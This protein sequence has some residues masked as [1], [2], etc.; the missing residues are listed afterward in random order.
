MPSDKDTSIIEN[1]TRIPEG[2]IPNDADGEEAPDSCAVAKPGDASSKETMTG[3]S[4][5]NET[6]KEK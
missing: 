6:D 2:Y 5:N 1:D 4:D 3:L